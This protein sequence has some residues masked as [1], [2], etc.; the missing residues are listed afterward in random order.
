MHT[1]NRIKSIQDCVSVLSLRFVDDAK[2]STSYSYLL[3]RLQLHSEMIKQLFHRV[4]QLK[5][6]Q[7]IRMTDVRLRIIQ[8]A[9]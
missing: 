5:H 3:A 6:C 9:P 8:V 1:P 7:Q 2:P 4:L